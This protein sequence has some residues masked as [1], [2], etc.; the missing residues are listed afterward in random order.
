V[1]VGGKAAHHHQKKS[2]SEGLR[3]SKP[4]ACVSPNYVSVYLDTKAPSPVQNTY[5][6]AVGVD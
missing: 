5:I 3:P 4:P 6:L 1:V 2:F